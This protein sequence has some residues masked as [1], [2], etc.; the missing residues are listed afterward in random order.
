MYLQPLIDETT[1]TRIFFDQYS[2]TTNKHT[3]VHT[4]IHITSEPQLQGKQGARLGSALYVAIK[5]DPLRQERML[6][7]NVCAGH[8]VDDD[9]STLQ[10]S[11]VYTEVYCLLVSPVPGGRGSHTYV[12]TSTLLLRFMCLAYAPAAEPLDRPYWNVRALSS[13]IS[14][15]VSMDFFAHTHTH[16]N[17]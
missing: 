15:Y 8:G 4:Y 12:G 11:L 1:R 2:N 9:Q 5:S 7:L 3:E 14:E 17:T 13:H 10:S 16:T 6:P